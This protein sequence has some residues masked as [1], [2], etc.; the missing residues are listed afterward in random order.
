MARITVKN[1]QVITA[2]DTEIQEIVLTPRDLDTPLTMCFI[3]VL[4]TATGIYFASGE[5]VD[6]AFHR[7]WPAGSK[8]PLSYK[9]NTSTIYY[10]AGAVGET[11][12]ITW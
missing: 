2:P 10:K 1:G 7:A 8:F 4:T 6:V 9:P 11:F 3:E 5:V 12:V